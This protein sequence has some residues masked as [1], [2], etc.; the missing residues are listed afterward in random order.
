[1]LVKKNWIVLTLSVFAAACLMLCGVFGGEAKTAHAATN[2]DG[3]WTT[4]QTT[5]LIPVITSGSLAGQGWGAWDWNQVNANGYYEN[6]TYGFGIRAQDTSDDLGTKSFTGGVYY[7]INLSDADKVKANLGQLTLYASSINW[8]QASSHHYISIRAEYYNSSDTLLSTAKSTY[9]QYYSS[10]RDYT[11]ELFQNKVPAGTEYIYVWFSNWGSLSGRP[12]IGKPT[13]YLYDSTAPSVTGAS[14]EQV[15]TVDPDN[16]IVIAGDTIKYYVEFNEKV[17]IS[18]AGTATINVGAN[19]QTSTAAEV[20]TENGKSKVGY[21]FQLGDFA[22]SG[23]VSF[24]SVSGLIVLDEANNSY[25][26]NGLP[27]ADTLQYYKKMT[28]GKSLSHVTMTGSSSAVYGTD[29]TAKLTAATGYYLPDSITVTVDGAALS[30]SSYTYLP[31][32]GSLRING[33]AIKGDIVVTASGVPVPYTVVYHANQPAGSSGA[34]SGSM[35]NSSFTYDVESALRKNV[36]ALAG[37]TFKGWATSADGSVL[38]EDGASVKNL[39]AENRGTVDLYAVWEANT[40]T[41]VYFA[42]RPTDAS[43]TPE[44]STADSGHTYDTAAPLTENGFS[45]TGW[46]FKGWATSA[47]GAVAYADCASVKNLTATDGGT[48][49]LY[50][51]WEANPYTVM[52]DSMGGTALGYVIATYDREMPAIT[53]PDKQGYIFNGYYSM[54][55]GGEVFYYDGEGVSVRKYDIDGSLTLYAKWTAIHY[56]IQFYS[57]GSYLTEQKDVEYGTMLLP[58]AESLSLTRENYIFLGWNIYQEQN[59]AMFYADTV[60]N[61]GIAYTDG[62]VVVLYA[63]WQEKPI[64]TL[65][66]DANGGSG[67]PSARDV[68]E[69][70]SIALDA[71]VPL[72]QNYTFLGWATAPDATEAVYAPAMRLRWAIRSLPSMPYGSLI[73][74]FPMMRTA[75]ILRQPSLRRTWRRALP[76]RLLRPVPIASDMLLRAGRLHPAQRKRN[77]DTEISSSCRR[78]IPSYMPYGQPIIIPLP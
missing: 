56:T 26:Y 41:V 62:S 70:E 78:R 39:T 32:D 6:S 49:N 55:D 35:V 18:S 33:K 61:T 60:Y 51:K 12:L 21:L 19:S 69:D 43:G 34:I 31:S 58:S 28:V 15:S 72:L 77:I 52:L 37:W 25:T 48:V 68:H 8:F 63:A 64:Y 71:T 42:N 40:F 76:S 22:A 46:T 36:Y 59:W 47:D 27:S 5:D 17:S 57:G 1:M 45:L 16:G 7:T 23:K 2:T 14:L 24:Q 38:Y 10:Q 9:D 73:R 53:V 3:Y 44:G 65:Y 50:A 13:C 54:T 66:Y 30:A 20:V 11:L 4:G 29:Y 74:C 67:A 75:A